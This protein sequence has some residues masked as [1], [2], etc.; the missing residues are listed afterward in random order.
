MGLVLLIMIMAGDY[1]AVQRDVAG[2]RSDIGVAEFSIRMVADDIRFGDA[3]GK[4]QIDSN[5]LDQAL[6]DLRAASIEHRFG[7]WFDPGALQFAY[8]DYGR[9]RGELDRLKH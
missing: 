5:M 7:A 1:S 2:L 8:E 3:S 6:S 9:V 4:L